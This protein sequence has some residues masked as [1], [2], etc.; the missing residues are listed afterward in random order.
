MVLFCGLSKEISN[1][2]MNK[3]QKVSQIVVS[4]MDR[5]QERRKEEEK[6]RTKKAGKRG[7]E[8][9]KFFFSIVNRLR[10]TSWRKWHEQIC[11]EGEGKK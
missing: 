7:T 4:A 10:K 11:E 9:G 5:E 1:N 3:K 2:Q 8:T 6:K